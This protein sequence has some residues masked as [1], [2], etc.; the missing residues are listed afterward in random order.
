MNQMMQIQNQEIQVK[1]FNGQR[2]V[3]FKDIDLVHERPSGTAKRNFLENKQ[4]FVD[5]QDYLPITRKEFGTKFVPN[6]KI[7]GNPNLTML[8]I[9]ESG[10]LML[11]KS[12]TDD[13][14]WAVQR[15]L[16][17]C[18]FKVKEACQQ[19]TITVTEKA[20]IPRKEIIRIGEAIASSS[21]H[22]LLAVLDVYRD[23][24]SPD[25][26]EWYMRTDQTSCSAETTLKMTISSDFSQRLMNLIKEKGISQNQ[27]SAQ[28]GIPK[29]TVSVYCHSGVT[30]KA[31]R[32]KKIAESM[33]VSVD[34]FYE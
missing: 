15:Q 18:Y 32:I 21:Q 11:V 33:N 25:V 4:H 3:T 28:S 24:I 19:A 30:P 27:F 31:E 22:N 5:G 1:E 12:F 13:L 20:G 34:Y 17:N 10:Y 14:A 23:F 9:T 8:L 29:S 16:V 7:V 26:L 2:V 6:E